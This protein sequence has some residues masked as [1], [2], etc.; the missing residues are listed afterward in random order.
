MCPVCG[1]PFLYHSPRSP[2]SGGPSDEICPSCGY[3]FGYDD[4]ARGISYMEWRTR[5]VAEGMTWFSHEG[6][7]PPPGWD[8]LKQL[9]NL[10]ADRNAD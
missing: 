5:W 10:D 3:Q 2:T 7:Q 9:R 4:D 6:R 1:Y 8:P